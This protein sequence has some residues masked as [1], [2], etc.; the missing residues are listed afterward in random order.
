M[1]VS[2]SHVAQLV[3]CL[4]T[5]AY[6][7]AADPGVASAILAQSHTLVEI[8][9]GHFPAFCCF[10]QEWLLSVNYKLKYVHKVLV[11]LFKLAQAKVWLGELTIRT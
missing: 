8:D 1:S 9:H 10:I 11:N 3:T 7:T 5:D 4:T 2:P 6:L